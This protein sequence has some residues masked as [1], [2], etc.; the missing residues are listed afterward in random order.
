[1][2]QIYKQLYWYNEPCVS[3][4]T[5]IFYNTKL[6]SVKRLHY[7]QNK[8]QHILFKLKNIYVANI[9]FLI[10]CWYI[11]IFKKK[12]NKLSHFDLFIPDFVHFFRTKFFNNSVS[13][14]TLKKSTIANLRLKCWIYWIVQISVLQEFKK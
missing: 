9:Y 14:Y 13:F 3:L 11:V 2:L 4:L 10:L 7:Y 12:N 5:P 6:I 8:I 1:M